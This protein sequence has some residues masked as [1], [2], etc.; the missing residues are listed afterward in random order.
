M[1]VDL[2]ANAGNDEGRLAEITWHN[3]KRAIRDLIP[4]EVNPRQITNKQAKDLK[5]SL[6]KFGIADPLIINTDNMIIGGHQRKKILETLLG[7]DPDFQIDVRVPDREL[8]IDEARELNVR[9]NKNVAD[10]DFDILANNFELDDLLDWGFDKHELDLDLWQPESEEAED[11]PVSDEELINRVPDAVWGSDNLYGIPMLDLNM[12][13]DHLE[14][15]F[16]G[17]GTMARKNKMTGTYHF[18]VEDN[19]FEQVWRNPIDVANSACYAL[20]EPNFSVYADMPKAVA[21]WQMFRKRWLARWFQSIGIRI[22]VD[23]NIAHRH[24]DLRFI[25]VPE[26]WKSYCTRAYSARLNETIIEYEEAV[27]HAGGGTILFVCY[28]GGK[29]AEALSMERGW[30]WYPDQQTQFAGGK[31]HG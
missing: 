20:V 24:D 7:Y 9:L 28:G 3:E 26:G 13:A 23:L 21:I 17:W 10:W 1:P 29:Q 11:E 25:G 12:Q 4:Y 22:I 31:K 19:R 5:A 2:L 27:K 30:I 8:S 14:A 16:A 15:P 18:Y 6:A